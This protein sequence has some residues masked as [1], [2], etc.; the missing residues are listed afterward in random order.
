MNTDLGGTWRYSK[1][2]FSSIFG[3]YVLVIHLV[4]VVC[5]PHDV[6]QETY[7]SVR[8]DLAAAAHYNYHYGIK[9]VRG[10]YIT[11]ERALAKEQ[12]K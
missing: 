5:W 10:A 2:A 9:L 7:D 3:Q 4:N 8:L 6:L 11:Q 12:S 1:V